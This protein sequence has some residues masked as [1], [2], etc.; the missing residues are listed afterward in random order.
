[1]RPMLHGLAPSGGAGRCIS[2]EVVCVQPAWLCSVLTNGCPL[3]GAVLS[4]IQGGYL[5]AG[6]EFRGNAGIR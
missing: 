5:L 3:G 6:L 2:E 4:C 1:M